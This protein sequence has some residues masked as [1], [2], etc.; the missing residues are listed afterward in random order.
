MRSSVHGAIV[1][2][3]KTTRVIIF[4]RVVYNQMESLLSE[5]AV[6]ARGV[7]NVAKSSAGSTLIRPQGVGPAMGGTFIPNN[8][9]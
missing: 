6:G 3:S 7:G 8:A 5:R 1:G 4:L 2:V 9:V